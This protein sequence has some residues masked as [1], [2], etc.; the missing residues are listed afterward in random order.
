MQNLVNNN[1]EFVFFIDFYLS[2]LV[3]RVRE[4][5]YLSKNLGEFYYI[6][7]PHFLPFQLT[8]A[9]SK[10]S[11]VDSTMKQFLQYTWLKN[12]KKLINAYIKYKHFLKSSFFNFF[13]NSHVFENISLFV[14]ILPFEWGQPNFK[15]PPAKLSRWAPE[16]NILWL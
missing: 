16:R 10:N 13:P 15:G 8:C 14:C 4:A 1:S 12:Q 2:I 9:E 11:E 5:K 6:F 7:V 3:I